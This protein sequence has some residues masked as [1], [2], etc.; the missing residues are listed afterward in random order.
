MTQDVIQWVKSCAAC[1]K[2][3]TPR[4]LRHGTTV[5]VLSTFPNEVLAIDILGPLME[6]SL[7]NF[8]L[9]TMIDPFT[10][11]PVAIP[12]PNHQSK[13]VAK[14]IF[15]HWICQKGVP[16]TIVS[17]QG[18][19]LVSQGMKALCVRLGIKKVQTSGYNPT[20]NAS[21]ERF[22]RYLMAS[23]SILFNQTGIEWDELVEPVL[24]AYRVSTNDATGFSPFLLE[25]GRHPN[26][27]AGVLANNFD[28]GE[29]EGEAE[30][31]RRIKTRLQAAFDL[32]RER[33]ARHLRG[34]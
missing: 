21:I 17:D 7:G 31:V 26:L 16:A 9:L 29:A 34:I 24:F 22:H 14:A 20:G 13:V 8:W 3:K 12:L 19:D 4:P 28:K 27:P 32:A 5:P 18:R 11:W 6:T 15:E 25:T 1:K 23:I 2:R 10:R 30:W 33:Q